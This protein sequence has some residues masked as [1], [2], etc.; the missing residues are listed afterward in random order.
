MLSELLLL[1]LPSYIDIWNQRER[2]GFPL[3][4]V[5]CVSIPF[6][7]DDDNDD[8][9]LLLTRPNRN[10]YSAGYHEAL[11]QQ[12]SSKVVADECTDRFSL[13]DFLGL[14]LSNK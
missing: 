13:L 10:L 12:G 7:A 2:R 9:I 8:S 1:L 11:D 3:G 5:D 6:G 4:V 14:C